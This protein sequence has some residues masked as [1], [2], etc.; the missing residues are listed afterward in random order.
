MAGASPVVFL[1]AVVA[2]TAE[3]AA[4]L[5]LAPFPAVRVFEPFTE[6][7][8]A[9]R[10]FAV[11]IVGT[12]AFFAVVFFLRAGFFVL[13]LPG[14]AFLLAFREAVRFTFVLAL[15]RLATGAFHQGSREKR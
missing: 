14:V 8:V 13:R 12:A 2:L 1:A 6:V 9:L 10:R 15:A 4:A 5:L 3:R 7:E 11:V